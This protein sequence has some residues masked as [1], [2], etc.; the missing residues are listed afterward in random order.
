MVFD[1]EERMID[2]Y[3]GI[4]PVKKCGTVV[5]FSRNFVYVCV[6]GHLRSFE[7]NVCF[8]ATKIRPVE[9]FN[10]IT[11]HFIQVIYVHGR[12]FSPPRTSAYPLGLDQM[13]K[14][15]KAGYG[16]T[17]SNI[18]CGGEQ[19]MRKERTKRQTSTLVVQQ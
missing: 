19:T 12:D 14:L 17:N 8:M 18:I 1:K 7:G 10:E 2:D 9:D 11:F 16:L 6:Y 13:Q 5:G 3:T 4:I 15:L